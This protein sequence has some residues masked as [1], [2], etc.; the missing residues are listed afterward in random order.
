LLVAACGDA[1]SDETVGAGGAPST[2]AA[3]AASE[4]GRSPVANLTPKDLQRVVEAAG[5]RPTRSLR[6]PVA[7]RVPVGS[8]TV[9]RIRI[10][11]EF[12]ARS[13]RVQVLVGSKPVGLGILTPTLDALVAVTTD[14]SGLV[15]GAAVAYQVEGAE[16]VAVGSLEVIS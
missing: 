15:R 9:W 11:G 6:G 1:P 7:E 4:E 5:T 10:P 3:P 2:T 14:G 16:P 12:Q 8:S 13:A